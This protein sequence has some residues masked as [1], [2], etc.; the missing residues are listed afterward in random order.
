M[1]KQQAA[2]QSRA[3][4][5]RDDKE[6]GE[7]RRLGIIWDVHGWAGLVSRRKRGDKGDKAAILVD[8]ILPALIGCHASSWSW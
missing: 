6:T 4:G 8:A 3:A 1:T 7:Y 5:E 2:E